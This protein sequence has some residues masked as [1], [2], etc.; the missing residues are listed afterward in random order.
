MCQVINLKEL[1]LLGYTKHT[2]GLSGI[3][4]YSLFNKQTTALHHNLK[5]VLVKN[6]ASFYK[7]DQILSNNKIKFVGI[8]NK[9]TATAITNSQIWIQREKLP[10]VGF[11]EM[12][13]VDLIDYYVEN[14][15]SKKIGKI[16]GF[17]NIKYQTMLI[18]NKEILIPFVPQIVIK[19]NQE[20]KQ[21]IVNWCYV[22]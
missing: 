16:T 9:T 7:I 1:I 15:K 14:T 13:L 2:C 20:A 22:N 8:N 11:D 5:V 18:I 21:I 3:L 6:T 4:S 12:Y 17:L 19:I 10:K